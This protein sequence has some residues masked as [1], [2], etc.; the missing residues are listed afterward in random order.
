MR[1]EIL[2]FIVI[3]QEE[4][5]D[6]PKSIGAYNRYIKIMAKLQRLSPIIERPQ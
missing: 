3:E 5:I 6:I 2:N 1:K 4:F